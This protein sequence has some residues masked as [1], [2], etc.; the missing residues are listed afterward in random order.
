MWS[1]VYLQGAGLA[2]LAVLTMVIEKHA[3]MRG[4]QRNA[5]PKWFDR[6]LRVL[7]LTLVLGP[8]VYHLDQYVTSVPFPLFSVLFALYLVPYSDLCEQ[9]GGRKT[10]Y[11][12]RWGVLNWLRRRF[13]LQL[14]KTEDLPA[15]KSYIFGIH[16][17]SV[18]PFGAML[19]LSDET[20]T[21]QFTKLFPGINFRTLAATFCFYIPGYREALLWGGVVDAARY[22]ARY[23][24]NNGYSLAVVP[25][26]ATEALYCHPDHDVVYIS[27]RRGFVKLAL[28]TG[29][30]L[31]PIFSF[32]ENN[33]YHLFGLES[34][35]VD[36]LKTK[37]QRIFGI[38][39]PLMKNILPRKCEI[40]VV[41][42][43][44]IPVPHI[45]APS[46]EEVEKYLDLYIA[47][48]KDLYNS[49]KDKYNCKDKGELK[50][51]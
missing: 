15:D 4:C 5:L 47:G 22:S 29:A 45:E 14:V 50:V 36:T 46:D 38:S 16:P 10:L 40:T 17:H 44:A 13:S 2:I 41:V 12:R 24:L 34:Q 39:L 26:G 28:E 3:A 19:A 31:V 27:R 49:N 30:S 32:N 23:I 8:S 33:T 20:E 43:R 1:L 7:F 37:F 51:M 42:G 18:L 48:L 6:S 21:S 11:A 9:R 25:G 35:W